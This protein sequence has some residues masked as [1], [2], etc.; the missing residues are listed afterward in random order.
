MQR[1]NLPDKAR[2]FPITYGIKASDVPTP[3]ARTQ[4]VTGTAEPDMLKLIDD[5][6]ERFGANFTVR[7]A[8]RFG[9]RKGSVVKEYL[10]RVDT[11]LVRTPDA[12]HRGRNTGMAGAPR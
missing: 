3:F 7:E 8:N 12:D 2:V 6:L 5:L 9:A 1:C 10:D 4:L 11:I